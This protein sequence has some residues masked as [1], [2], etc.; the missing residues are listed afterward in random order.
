MSPVG[1]C[2]VYDVTI[3]DVN[4]YITSST[5][6]ANRN[7]FDELTQFTEGIYKYIGLGRTRSVIPG[8]KPKVRSATNPGGE[9]H[10]WVKKRFLDMAPPYT[11]KV[12]L[13]R[14]PI[15]GE[16]IPRSRAFVPASLRD[17]PILLA[18]NPE[19]ALQLAELPENER[20]ALLEGRW[21]LFEGQAFSQWSP[22][23][24]VRPF[25]IPPEWPRYY[26]VDYGYE[27]PWC[28]L[29]LAMNLDLW[30]HQKIKRY[31]CY[32]EMHRV[33]TPAWMQAVAI[34]R[35]NGD[36]RIMY[37][38]ADASMW[39]GYDAGT[40]LIGHYERAGLWPRKAPS[41][42]GS[43]IPAKGAV[44]WLL[45]RAQDGLPRLQIFESCRN[46]VKDL[47]ALQCDKQH[48]EDVDTEGPD[49]GFDAL[50]GFAASVVGAYQRHKPQEYKIC[51]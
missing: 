39:Q 32:H 44:D 9:G 36:Q 33:G 43:R 20:R 21:D 3:A 51:A 47:P 45:D 19:Y 50:K 35:Q 10:T 5:G 16:T 27:A 12:F 30:I 15:T 6:L 23:H 37:G 26:T 1:N 2:L 42:T 41:G 29:W 13:E 46:L 7:C 34:K 22:L 49:H 17:N 14:H 28:T 25:A 11:V 4:H 40:S 38:V 31:Y 24:V 48:P 8:A 18:N